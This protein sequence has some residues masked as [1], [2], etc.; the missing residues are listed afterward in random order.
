MFAIPAEPMPASRSTRRRA[1]PS[2]ETNRATERTDGQGWSDTA[3]RT[4]HGRTDDGHRFGD[5]SGKWMNFG[6]KMTRV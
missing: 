2:E 3:R 1:D 6:G 4:V 5:G